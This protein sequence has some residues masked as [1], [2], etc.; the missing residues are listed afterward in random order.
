MALHNYDLASYSGPGFKLFD[1]PFVFIKLHQENLDDNA[2][3][4][5]L[6]TYVP[7]IV[8]LI[9]IFI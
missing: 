8:Q 3:K 2:H 1:Y 7:E 9:I 6:G 4:H 5:I